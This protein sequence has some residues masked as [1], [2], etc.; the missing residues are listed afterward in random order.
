MQIMSLIT[1]L[2]GAAAQGLIWGIMAIGVYIT[3]RILDIADLTVDGTLCT[4]GA[5]CIMMMLSGHNVWVSMLV[6]TGAGLLAGLATG[7]F[8]T[9][10]GIPAILA[11]I[12]T[13]LSLYSVNLK[14]M[15]KANQAINVDKFNLLVSLRRVKGVA[16]TQN[17]LFIVAIMIIILIAVL[18]WFFGTELGC[19]LRATGCNPSMSRAQGINTDRNKV[20]GLMLSNGLVALS[21]ALLTQYQG[22][23]DI[24]M[25]RGSIVIGLAAVIIGEAIFS[26]IFRNFAL[27]LLSVVFGSILY[28]LVLQIVIWMGIDTDLLKML[29][30]LVVAFFLAF[31]YWKGKYFTKAKQGGK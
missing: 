8:H 15:G 18:Y 20:L 12:L 22:F 29:S 27:K 10:M 4:G 14:I 24:N 26:R 5:V 17:T 6:A 25:G 30:A 28:Y 13:Q 2:P 9:F 16:L 19:S 23:A 3:F 21:G 1:A 31:P 7:I 11:G